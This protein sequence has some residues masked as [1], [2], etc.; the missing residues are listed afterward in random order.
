MNKNIRAI[1]SDI[2]GTLLDSRRELA[3]V[4]IASI[5]RLK[6]HMPV[7]LASS[8]MPAAMRHLQQQL[9][10]L[11]QPLICFNGGY[12][13]QYDQ[14]SRVKII[15]DVTLSLETVKAILD[16]TSSTSLHASIYHADEWFAPQIDH[17]SERE[18]TITKVKPTIQP[19][20]LTISDFERRK[21]GAHKIM[22]MGDANELDALQKHL[23]QNHHTQ[24]HAYRSK[25]TYLEI[26][27]KAISK[28]SALA[29]VM[30]KTFDMSIDDVMA[31]GDNYNDVEMLEKVGWGV[32]VMN[33]NDSVKRVAKEI[34]ASNKEDGV[35][36][37][38]EKYFG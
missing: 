1:C 24:L 36:K 21:I 4:T 33:G 8:R 15:H 14:D 26:T 25:D 27:P 28:A 10:I 12:C 19:I 35:S 20:S 2:D 18:S 30:E 17:W 9:G 5:K 34:T 11:D 7:V 23:E 6:N 3:E 31:F 29:I 37:I 16:K 13:I 22:C 32:A 38:L